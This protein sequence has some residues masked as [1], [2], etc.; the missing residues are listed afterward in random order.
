MTKIEKDPLPSID[1]HFI[2]SLSVS[3]SEVSTHD[4]MLSQG[5]SQGL[6]RVSSFFS[7]A[8][9]GLTGM[10]GLGQ[11]AAT[12][13]GI[14][15]LPP[16]DPIPSEH[17]KAII[18]DI[19]LVNNRFAALHQEFEELKKVDPTKADGLAFLLL[20]ELLK[21]QKNQ[22]QNE[23]IPE[24][25]RRVDVSQADARR[26]QKLHSEANENLANSTTYSGWI[27]NVDLALNTL[28]SVGTVGGLI[29]APLTG[30]TSLGG[31]K[32]IV[33]MTVMAGKVITTGTKAVVEHKLKGHQANTFKLQNKRDLIDL[34]MTVALED[35]K[36]I[37]S[38]IEK[39]ASMMRDVIRKRANTL[40]L[41]AR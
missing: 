13:S 16:A 30:G 28:A 1:S 21:N 2:D 12:Q 20:I 9:D 18:A 31:A 26:A 7:N 11:T 32:A 19:N 3:E 35:I 33:D 38:S 14:P 24:A 29:A 37:V 17:V 40:T 15:Q 4:S 25:S 22:Y 41:F 39:I 34:Q 23:A 8:F 36:Q 5:V 10:L 6:N 27:D